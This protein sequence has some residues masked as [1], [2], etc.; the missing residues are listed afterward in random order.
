MNAVCSSVQAYIASKGNSSDGPEK[1]NYNSALFLPVEGGVDGPGVDGSAAG[2]GPQVGKTPVMHSYLAK[3]QL[4]ISIP[5][6][7]IGESLPTA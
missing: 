6:T 1:C 2:S 3:S 5:S 4:R 7:P